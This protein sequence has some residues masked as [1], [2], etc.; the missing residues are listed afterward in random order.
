MIVVVVCDCCIHWVTYICIIKL[1]WIGTTLAWIGK[2]LSWRLMTYASRLL[3]NVFKLGVMLQWYHMHVHCNW[4]TFGVASWIAGK[5]D[6]LLL[7]VVDLL[8]QESFKGC[9]LVVMLC[10]CFVEI[11]DVWKLWSGDFIWSNLIYYLSYDLLYCPISHPL[12]FECCP[13]LVTCRY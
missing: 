12:L 2:I 10:W 3:A 13:L 6:L 11:K 4:V 9:E 8:W 1:S 5:I 7:Y